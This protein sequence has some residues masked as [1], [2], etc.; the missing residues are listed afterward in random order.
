MN[1]RDF[2]IALVV[3]LVVAG[4]ALFVLGGTA[5]ASM[6]E[7]ARRTEDVPETEPTG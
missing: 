6:R 7:I 3:F 2:A 1:G 4:V 5:R